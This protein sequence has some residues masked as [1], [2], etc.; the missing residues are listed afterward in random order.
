MGLAAFLLIVS[1]VGL[2]YY[3]L[4]KHLQHRRRFQ[5]IP[6][7]RSLPLLGHMLIVK[8]DTE[9]FMD[10]I[11]GMAAM[12]PEKPR[13]VTFWASVLPIV[14]I[15]SPESLEPIFTNPKH[16]NKPFLYALL[17]PWLGKG[18]LTAYVFGFSYQF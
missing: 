17:E 3:G 13:M 15:Y 11:M 7:P 4:F 18:L 14:M 6:S 5:G 9:G 16:L 8:P 1:I 12:Y 2:L 10:Q